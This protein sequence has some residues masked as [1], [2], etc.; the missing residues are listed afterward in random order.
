MG[1]GGREGEE[2]HLR[3]E[4]DEVRVERVAEYLPPPPPP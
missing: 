2:G 4:V 1:C 3:Q